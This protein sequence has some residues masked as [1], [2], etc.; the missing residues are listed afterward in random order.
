MRTIE[1]TYLKI[2]KQLCNSAIQNK[3]FWI[4]TFICGL[5]A[6]EWFLVQSMFDSPT[7][8]VFFQNNVSIASFSYIEIFHN[9]TTSNNQ[10]S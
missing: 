5:S 3:K 2:M 4:E 1:V 10:G 7:K 9:F 8:K 6:L